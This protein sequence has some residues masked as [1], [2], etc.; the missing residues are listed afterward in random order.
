M[1]YALVEVRRSSSEAEEGALLDAVHAALVAAF[2]VPE[3]VRV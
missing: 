1:P 2:R 3:R